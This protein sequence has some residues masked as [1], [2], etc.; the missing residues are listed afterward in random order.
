MSNLSEVLGP[1]FFRIIVTAFFNCFF[2]TL[3]GEP[4]IFDIVTSYFGALKSTIRIMLYLHWFAW[5]AE[6]FGAADLS[7]QAY[8]Y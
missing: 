7:R 2:R 6:N 8:Y 4:G 1:R 3:T 5:L